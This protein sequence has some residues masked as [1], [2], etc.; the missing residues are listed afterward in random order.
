MTIRSF[1]LQL[2]GLAALV[3]LLLLFLH[4][5][6][7]IGEYQSFSWISWLCFIGISFLMFFLGKWSAMHR[8]RNLFV[9]ISILLG[10]GK[11]LLAVLLVIVYSKLMQP[12]SRA[13]VIPFFL[14]Y[15][16]FTIFETYFMMKLAREKRS[17]D[18]E[19][20]SS[21]NERIPS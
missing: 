10:G 19:V 14:V 16:C 12:T 9:S 7:A 1:V 6:P 3:A 4:Q 17:A 18:L 21:E 15:L 2:A 8:D 11:M 20:N 13:F 5:F